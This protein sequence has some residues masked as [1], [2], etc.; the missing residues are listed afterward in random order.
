MPDPSY[1]LDKTC[2]R[3]LSTMFAHFNQET[4]GHCPQDICVDDNEEWRQGLWAVNEFNCREEPDLEDPEDPF[5]MG[6]CD[7]K[8]LWSWTAEKYPPQDG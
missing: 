6:W 5:A 3:E 8:D 1:D 7:Y 4:G 2:M